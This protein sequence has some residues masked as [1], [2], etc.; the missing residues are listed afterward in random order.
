VVHS[1]SKT[2]SCDLSRTRIDH[3]VESI[4]NNSHF[5]H[6]AFIDT[7]DPKDIGHTLSNLNWVN[8]MHEK[9]ENFERNQD[10]ELVDPP[11]RCKPIGIKWVW[12]NK[13]GEKCQKS[14]K[15]C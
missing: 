7:F 11:P 4:R 2:Q 8:S 3:E 1:P 14:V 13:K 15:A 12:K 5:A 10:W 6:A 9:F